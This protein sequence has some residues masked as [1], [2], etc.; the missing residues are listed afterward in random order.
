VASRKEEKERL[1]RE[2]LAAEQAEARKAATRRRLWIV[3]GAVIAVAAVAAVIVVVVS[4]TGGDNGGGDEAAGGGE[5]AA[6]P[7]PPVKVS[8]LD[9]AAKAAGCTVK[10]FPSEGREHIA[11]PNQK[12]DYKTNPPTSG[13]HYQV[14]ADD[15]DY[16]GK[17]PPPLT[18]TVHSLEHGRID[19]QYPPGTPA[20][21]IG[22]LKSLMNENSGYHALLFENQSN[23]DA[24]VAATAWTHSIT[25]PKVTAETFDAIRA[26]RERY[27]DQGPEQIP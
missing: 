8:G 21:Q 13:T 20:R 11:D 15:G 3:L 14:P 24:A 5:I 16:S 17:D 18:A 9:Q 1:R 19:I 23:M 25:C 26:F 22:Q 27:T 6:V 7:I 2:R 4:A 12:V 10:T